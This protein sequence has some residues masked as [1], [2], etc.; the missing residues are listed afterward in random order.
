MSG[1]GDLPL[2]RSEST[3]TIYYIH[4]DQTNTPQKMTDASQ[5][6]VWDRNQQ[7][8]GE[9]VST[10]GS[11][12]NHLRR[13]PARLPIPPPGST[14]TSTATH[15]PTLGRY[16]EADPLGLAGGT[17]CMGLAPTFLSPAAIWETSC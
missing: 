15:H 9:T 11:T 12:T 1:L 2:A 16:I 8:F 13:P 7:P 6:V 5:A 4:S 17:I 3:A 14:T 10:T